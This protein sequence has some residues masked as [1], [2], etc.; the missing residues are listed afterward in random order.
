VLQREVQLPRLNGSVER[1]AFR[2]DMSLNS[3]QFFVAGA[4]RNATIEPP[5]AK[6]TTYLTATV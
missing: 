3:P 2:W 5:G 4:G 1:R 6:R